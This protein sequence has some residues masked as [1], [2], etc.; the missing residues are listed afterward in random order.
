MQGLTALLILVPVTLPVAVLRGLVYD[1][2]DVSEF[3][4]SLF[5]SINMVGAFLAAPAVGLLA[6][7]MGHR[8][9]IALIA[10]L[11]DSACFFA[12]TLPISF[13]L[14]MAVRFFEGA[15]H[16]AA[17]SMLLSLASTSVSQEHRG[18]ALGLT[19]AGLLLGVAIGAPLGGWI[20]RN[21]PLSPLFLGGVIVL[22]SAFLFL[23]GVKEQDPSEE[24]TPAS[25]RD[26]IRAL[27]EDFRIVVPLVF[28]FAD[29]FTVG[30]Y[31]TT[32]SLYLSRV[33]E[34]NPPQIGLMITA[35]MLPFA[36]LSYPFG[37]LS[38]RMSRITLLAVGS[39]F[40]GLGTASLT[41]W[42]MTSLPLV[43]A[44]LGISA[45]V[46]FVPTMLL[47]TEY[48][49]DQLRSTAL[50]GF[51]AAG[52]LGFIAGPIVGGLVSQTFGGGAHWIEGYRMAFWVAGGSE[53]C[54]VL[55]LLPLL[56]LRSRA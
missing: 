27:A 49:S 34:L 35:F 5:M 1:R 44:F 33:H 9:R 18:R 20:G 24:Q 52:S 15:T 28:A 23:F 13:P 22:V 32:F 30:F 11:L 42:S 51:N 14:F 45:A 25:I 17:L 50:S 40:Y 54:L 16:I 43:M 2:F 12:L 8:K 39:V 19:G 21:D 6:D 47:T 48:A 26:L 53:I 41:N 7:R 56:R 55:L 36:L 10:L 31:T 46:M 38:E 29:R 4:T 3:E 37:W